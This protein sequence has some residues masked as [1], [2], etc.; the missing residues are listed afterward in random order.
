MIKNELKIYVACLAS[1]NAGKYHG[2]WLDALLDLDKLH[3]KV[4]AM[5]NKSEQEVAEDWAIHDYEG[6]GGLKLSEYESLETI[7][8]LAN[9][10][11][12]HGNL[13]IEV[14][15]YTY[16]SESDYDIS[17]AENMLNERYRGVFGSEEDFAR[18][19]YEDCF[20]IPKEL[21]MYIDYEAIANDLMINDYLSI[22]LNGEYHIFDEW[23]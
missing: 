11:E 23:R 9:F 5:L 6:F 3:E 20:D 16:S 10:I 14:L 18:D 2:V 4:Q 7:S 19:L 15:K 13:G 1:Y 21:E 22:E 8:E 17:E 12:E